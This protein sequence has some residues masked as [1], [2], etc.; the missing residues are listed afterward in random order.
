[1]E[2]LR[3][4]NAV[5][6][7]GAHKRSGVFHGL[8]RL[9]V[10]TPQRSAGS[11]RSRQRKVAIP[12]LFA[13]HRASIHHGDSDTTNDKLELAY[14]A[15]CR[16]GGDVS[17]TSAVAR[18]PFLTMANGILEPG[19]RPIT[20]LRASCTCGSRHTRSDVLSNE[21]PRI[22]L[23]VAVCGSRIHAARGVAVV[24]LSCVASFA[25]TEIL[26]LCASMNTLA[27]SSVS[28]TPMSTP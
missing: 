3:V 4:E 6:G 24:P 2:R 20:T 13:D 27:T 22:D 21:G 11:A 25:D 1:M 7:R 10:D 23:I 9:Q 17:W 19:S 16:D 15:G 12:S 26:G 14:R 8:L 28:R 5:R 18:F